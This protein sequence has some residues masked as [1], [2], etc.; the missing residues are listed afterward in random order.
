[1]SKRTRVFLIILPCLAL[2]IS[3]IIYF[4]LSTSISQFLDNDYSLLTVYEEDYYSKTKFWWMCLA[5]VPICIIP[6]IFGIKN[7][8]KV[9]NCV[10]I[11]IMLVMVLSS[12]VQLK[13]TQEYSISNE[14]L[15]AVEKNI[16]YDFPDGTNVLVEKNSSQNSSVVCEGVI[17]IPTNE[18]YIN[19][20]EN[21]I[22]WNK[23]I[24]SNLSKYFSP[25]FNLYVSSLNKYVYV[26]DENNTATFLA[27][28]SEENILFFSIVE[29]S[30]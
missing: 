20:L 23:E 1:M 2:F 28:Q 12:C 18:E 15:I 9:V 30:E 21:N 25:T 8:D 27:Y 14:Y 26:I 3:L 29:I 10:S 7:K 5:F 6:L 17:R 11:I 22:S 4:S 19:D 24:D 16:N 13:G